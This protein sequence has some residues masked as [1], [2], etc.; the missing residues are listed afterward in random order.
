MALALAVKKGS[1]LTVGSHRMEVVAV[2]GLHVTVACPGYSKVETI[3]SDLERQ[4]VFPD[5]WM[6]T[7][8][9]KNNDG[10]TRIVFEAPR[11]IQIMRDDHDTESTSR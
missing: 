3:L 6:S 11:I 1:K 5:V 9:S 4:Q 2:Q 7:S 8:K 10:R